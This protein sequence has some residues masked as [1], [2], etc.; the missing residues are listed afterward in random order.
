MIIISKKNL[1]FADSD[2]IISKPRKQVDQKVLYWLLS[3]SFYIWG[4][5]FSAGPFFL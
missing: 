1:A 4:L 3:R 2:I 5:Q